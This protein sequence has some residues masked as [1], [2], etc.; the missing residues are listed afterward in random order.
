MMSAG[1]YLAEYKIDFETD[2]FGRIKEPL[3]D[4]GLM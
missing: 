1:I 3:K 2:G 4:F